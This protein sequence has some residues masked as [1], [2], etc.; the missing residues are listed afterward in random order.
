MKISALAFIPIFICVSLAVNG[1]ILAEDP[2][3][4]PPPPDQPTLELAPL[5]PGVPRQ[6]AQGRW[7]VDQTFPLQAS[8]D[9]STLSVGGP[10]EFGYTWD[11]SVP[12]AWIDATSGTDAG[13]SGYEQ[14]INVSLP[15]TFKYYENEY[16]D[17]WITSSG[18][19]SFTSTSYWVAF[20]DIPYPRPP[21]DV[22]APYWT[23]VDLEDSGPDGRVYYTSG[24]VSPNRYF[25]VEWYQVTYTDEMYTFEV[26]LYENGD[27]LFQYQAMTYVGGFWY[28]GAAGLEDSAGE[29]GLNY[30]PF[31][32]KAPVTPT[33][34]YFTRPAP[35]ARAKITPA[36]E[37]SFAS[38][39][40]KVAFE[41]IVKNTGELG[42]DTYDLTDN[43]PWLVSYFQQDGITPLTD[44]DGDSTVDTGVIDPN[45]S[46]TLV[47]EIEAPLTADVGDLESVTVSATSSL[48]MNNGDSIVYRLAI[49]SRFAQIYLDDDDNAMGFILADPYSR[50]D[51]KVT[52]NG[53]T[54]YGMAIA[55]TPGYVY[56]WSKGRC[57]GSPCDVYVYEIQYTLLDRDGNTVLAVTKLEDH[58]A[59]TMT[60][61]DY[62]VAVA[63]APDGHI[64][65][66]W[67]RTLH[68]ASGTQ[69]NV[70][71]YFAILDASGALTF[72][73]VNMTGNA[74]WGAHG[75]LNVPFF[76]SPHIEATGDNHFVLT[77]DR[78]TEEVP[79][80]V[81]DIYY[82]VRGSSGSVI[83]DVTKLTSSIAGDSGHV[84][85]V[86][87]PLT[88]NRVFLSWIDYDNYYEIYF[89]V[90]DSAGSLVKSATNLSEDYIFSA[91]NNYDAVELD[92]GHILAA[93]ESYSCIPGDTFSGVRYAVLDSSYN[94]IGAPHCLGGSPLQE[95]MTAS[96]TAD[97]SGHG[98]I[99]W[100]GDSDSRIY[101]ALIDKDG[102]V[103][104]DPIAFKSAT[105]PYWDDGLLKTAI[106]G[107]GNAASSLENFF[108]PII[109]K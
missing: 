104:T 16:S 74:A 82:A 3:P 27:I 54:G 93:W 94:R 89:V 13:M 4:T 18:Y 80:A 35:A 91:Y 71:I 76:Y 83:K 22:I 29:D 58:S 60:T 66:L 30:V 103:L 78:R 47:V 64:G 1:P 92:D 63:V 55:E 88:G 100:L 8:D 68:N 40:E 43:S 90:M 37:D 86:L 50:L 59:A 7:V 95:D 42:S 98:I 53:A 45:S 12:F 11:D 57:L 26:I 20:S 48:D 72:G 84:E 5:P 62:P 81:N 25:A 34:V 36:T 46:L 9:I 105:L 85:P 51:R 99:T 32:T 24:G 44:T 39:G 87:A 52:G 109:Q 97:D 108:L 75:A 79:G 10:D 107:Y 17:V 73:P 2:P 33:A 67:Y 65:L 61:V 49:P 77:W 19:L 56:A 6:D 41:I 101:Y 14:A 106:G 96:V 102:V 38:P 70:N 69:F 28:C 21:N 31:C 15:F 23:P